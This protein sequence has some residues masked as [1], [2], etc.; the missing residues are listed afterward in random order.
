VNFLT[1][2]VKKDS[3][4]GGIMYDKIKMITIPA[5]AKFTFLKYLYADFGLLLD[6]QTNYS[7]A[8]AAPNQSGIG[9][10]GG[11]GAKYN[12]GSVQVFVDPYFQYHGLTQFNK[13]QGFEL[14][15]S[16]VKFGVGYNF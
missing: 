8:S 4:F 2:D 11:L 9:F 3:F 16:G 13:G 1:A 7:T 6:F 14:L 12:F 15:N 10:E 5:I